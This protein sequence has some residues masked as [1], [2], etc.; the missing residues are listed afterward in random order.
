MSWLFCKSNWHNSL[1]ELPGVRVHCVG[2]RVQLVGETN[3]IVVSRNKVRLRPYARSLPAHRHHLAA[4][5]STGPDSHPEGRR[6]RRFHVAQPLLKRT[7]ID[8]RSVA[9]IKRIQLFS[10]LLASAPPPAPFSLIDG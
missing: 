10:N 3:T 5:P 6:R 8:R 4:F 2:S 9:L 1:S 7:T